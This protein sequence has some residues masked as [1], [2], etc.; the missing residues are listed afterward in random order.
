MLARKRTPI[1]PLDLNFRQFKSAIASY[2]LRHRDGAVLIESG[3][4]S[5]IESLKAG[6]AAH[7][8]T[9]QDVTHVFLTHIHLDHAGAAGWLAQQ[10]VQVCVHPVGAPHIREPEKLL[11]SAL[12]LYGDEMDVLW[13]QFLPVPADKIVEVQDGQEITIGNLRF[14]AIHTTGHARHHAVYLFEDI[15]FTGDIGGAR[16][17]GAPYVRLPLVPP[18]LNLEDWRTSLM[19]LKEINF[20]RVAPTH[21]GIYNDASQ[22]L[23]LAYRA[24]DETERWLEQEMH[25][26]PP[27][28]TLRVRYS[29]WQKEQALAAGL[30]EGDIVL[31]EIGNPTWMGAD[32]LQRYWKK[33]RMISLRT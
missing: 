16:L 22:H 5:T 12:R 29:A 33:V 27:I 21:F 9:P 6:L 15:C 13:G 2:L 11:A 24:L 14:T 25:A 4:G 31:H 1:F 7:G 10:G 8:L 17:P 3:P 18:E 20:R 30:S 26:D 32:G 23:S 28:G 19:K